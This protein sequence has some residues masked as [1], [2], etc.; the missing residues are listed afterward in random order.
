MLL[1]ILLIIILDKISMLWTFLLYR[2]QGDFSCTIY[3]KQR[4]IYFVFMT[5]GR[6][7]IWGTD[8]YRVPARNHFWVRMGTRYQPETFLV[9]DEYWVPELGKG[10]GFSAP[11]EPGIPGPGRLPDW[12]SNPGR[13]PGSK[14]NFCP[15]RKNGF[16]KPGSKISGPG[17]SA[18]C[19]AL[20]GTGQIFR[21]AY[22]CSWP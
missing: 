21:N 6:H 4:S 17:R 5:S 11:P 3:K 19:R 18:R 13:V 15:S 12:N 2:Y 16:W 1:K 9:T 14:L 10:P 7:E 22:P 8:G 20:L